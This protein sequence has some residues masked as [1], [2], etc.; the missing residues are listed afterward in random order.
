MDNLLRMSI[1]VDLYMLYLISI[2]DSNATDLRLPKTLLNHY[3][4]ICTLV[5]AEAEFVIDRDNDDF[6]HLIFTTPDDQDKVWTNLYDFSKSGKR[7][8]PAPNVYDQTNGK[9]LVSNLNKFVE[10]AI[11]ELENPCLQT[12]FTFLLLDSPQTFDSAILNQEFKAILG[13]GIK[14]VMLWDHE[15]EQPLAIMIEGDRD[16]ALMAKEFVKIIYK[17][18]NDNWEELFEF[19]T[20]EG[21]LGLSSIG[22][23]SI[24]SKFGFSDKD[25]WQTISE[26]MQMI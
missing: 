23:I 20:E 4:E 6:F 25:Y 10:S 1:A 5:N 12:L 9:L 3:K 16:L 15:K 7:T 11:K 21:A 18:T 14:Y 13:T 22:N 26:K 8:F 17:Q 2:G 19:W 24:E